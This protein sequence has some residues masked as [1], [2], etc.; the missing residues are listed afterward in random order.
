MPT[1]SEYAFRRRSSTQAGQFWQNHITHGAGS[2]AWATISELPDSHAILAWE[3]PDNEAV[4]DLHAMA[5]SPLALSTIDANLS[6]AVSRS[7]EVRTTYLTWDR[8]PDEVRRA[9]PG[10]HQPWELLTTLIIPFHASLPWYCPDVDGTIRYYVFFYLDR[11]GQL[12]GRID[13]WY[14]EYSGWAGV[15][16]GELRRGLNDGVPAG[17]RPLQSQIDLGL[18]LFAD[19]RTF[20]MLYYL[21]GTGTRSGFSEDDADRRIA[22]AVIPN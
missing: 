16:G 1:L 22:L 5:N 7:G 14:W 8:V 19:D 21:P 12:R 3:R 6:G 11:G 9:N 17:I 20:N 13:G 10:L 18:R 2:W 15:C 4:I